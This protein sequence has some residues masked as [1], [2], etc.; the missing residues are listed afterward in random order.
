MLRS[1]RRIILPI[2]LVCCVLALGL[3]LYALFFS[4]VSSVADL[5][6]DDAVVVVSF[7]TDP[8][9]KQNVQARELYDEYAAHGLLTEGTTRSFRD[10]YALSD[11]HY[12]RDI[13]PWL[14]KE[15]VLAK[16]SKDASLML[17]MHVGDRRAARDALVR[18]Q[19]RTHSGTPRLEERSH[20]RVSY[21]KLEAGSGDVFYI[22]FI[23]GY[24]VVAIQEEELHRVIDVSRRDA[25]PLSTN[26][27]YITVAKK[28]PRQH[29]VFFYMDTLPNLQST[30]TSVF[31]DEAQ[32]IDPLDVK[33]LNSGVGA[34]MV[35]EED[36]FDTHIY[37]GEREE[38]VDGGQQRKGF[39][40]RGF[41]VLP[42][43]TALFYETGSLDLLAGLVR[44][45][46]SSDS[47]ILQLIDD[48]D[49]MQL[50][51]GLGDRRAIVSLLPSL[52]KGDYGVGIILESSQNDV[53]STTLAHIE[54]HLLEQNIVGRGQL[55]EDTYQDYT[56]RSLP[57]RVGGFH[58][59]YAVVGDMTIIANSD[60]TM[61]LL[62]DSVSG[63]VPNL[64]S[65]GDLH[66]GF[67]PISINDP[68]SYVYVDVV[69]FLFKS[70]VLRVANDV[71]FVHQ[72]NS[73]TVQ[74]LLQFFQSGVFANSSVDDE[75]R[76]QGY[77]KVR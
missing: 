51:G 71:G 34:V 56:I 9:D 21:N 36:G 41:D 6:P 13:R 53:R 47:S 16:S 39:D 3:A 7:V 30:L 15:I 44:Q 31:G 18:L 22:A 58:L 27:S 52:R 54:S 69:N 11:L 26:A 75:V 14:G 67:D 10:I 24:V 43:D 38:D 77:L 19:S 35:A 55:S 32:V 1:D 76:I 64:A 45:F 20:K 33:I 25:Q 50:I 4:R 17:F 8:G 29:A 23:E 5:L 37:L 70:E 12:Q 57:L 73:Q 74:V 46:S 63:G 65:R 42:A 60:D 28:L 68:E 61:C 2:V 62:I 40:P 49:L 66:N 72:S 48:A 59:F